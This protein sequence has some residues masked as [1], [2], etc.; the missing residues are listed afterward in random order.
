MW[1]RS[2]KNP[3]TGK[4]T[5]ECIDWNGAEFFKGEFSSVADADRAG[6]DAERRM[7]MA[8]QMPVEASTQVDLS[9]DDLLAELLA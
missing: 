3:I 8:M 2:A 1:H 4:F 9:D 5:V 7:T 6:E